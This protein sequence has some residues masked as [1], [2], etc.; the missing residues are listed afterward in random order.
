MFLTWL[1]TTLSLFSG[2]GFL[3]IDQ[4]SLEIQEFPT[5]PIPVLFIQL[6]F[7][8]CFSKEIEGQVPQSSVHIAQAKPENRLVSNYSKF[9]VLKNQ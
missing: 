6:A 2:L 1:G 5:L 9:I 8:P 3:N 7:P 4:R